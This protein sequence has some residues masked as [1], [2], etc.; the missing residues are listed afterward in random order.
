MNYKNY[1]KQRLIEQ[2]ALS[3]A[4]FQGME[5]GIPVFIPGFPP[6]PNRPLPVGPG[7]PMGADED[8]DIPR[9][10]EIPQKPRIP[11]RNV[12]PIAPAPTDSN[13][14]RLPGY[15][16]LHM[17]PNGTYEQRWYFPNGRYYIWDGR[18]WNDPFAPTRA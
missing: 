16:A 14:N 2:L 1:F 13:G 4:E 6:D 9:L 3:E 12:A 11:D 8:P 15:P 18:R 10:W 5:D 7:A 17:L